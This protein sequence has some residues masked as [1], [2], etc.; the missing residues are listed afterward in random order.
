M[1]EGPAL[2]ALSFG[3]LGK[4]GKKIDTIFFN[5]SRNRPVLLK[6]PDVDSPQRAGRTIQQTTGY[7]AFVPAPLPPDPPLL[8]SGELQMVKA[9]E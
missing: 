1:Q 4:R 3:G 5:K 6:D 2:P 9:I 8:Y 7:K